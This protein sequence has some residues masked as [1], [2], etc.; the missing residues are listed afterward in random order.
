MKQVLLAAAF[1]GLT[2]ITP[3]ASSKQLYDKSDVTDLNASAYMRYDFGGSKTLPLAYGLQLDYVSLKRTDWRPPMLR[4][5]FSGQDMYNLSL[6][7]INMLTK[8]L[9]L[10]A[11]GEVAT[12]TGM[13][14][15]AV[16]GA[17]GALYGAYKVVD[18]D[19]D[20]CSSGSGC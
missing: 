5:D 19:A 8:E 6:V 15:L 2:S 13:D 17:V 10:N 9:Y 3:Y 11:D 4:L 18:D 16:I 1:A 14:F 12:K 20:S 7:G